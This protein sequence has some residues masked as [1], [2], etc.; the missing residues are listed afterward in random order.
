MVAKIVQVAQALSGGTSGGGDPIDPATLLRV[1]RT[2]HGIEYTG[3]I[4]R[5]IDAARV[6]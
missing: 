1:M 3:H 6:A 5:Q 4:E 2:L